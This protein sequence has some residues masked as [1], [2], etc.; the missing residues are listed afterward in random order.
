MSALTK[1]LFKNFVL[2]TFSLKMSPKHA[3]LILGPMLSK[4]LSSQQGQ[5]GRITRS[6]VK[7]KS[8]CKSLICFYILKESQRFPERKCLLN[9][10]Q[11]TKCLLNFARS[12]IC[13]WHLTLKNTVKKSWQTLT[14]QCSH[15]KGMF[16][17]VFQRFVSG[18]LI[19]K[20]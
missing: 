14:W 11:P 4:G 13:L 9:F 16:G 19:I 15:F 10:A 6:N 5:Q 20:N 8:K 3:S 2:L 12:T 7:N 1:T 18:L 17:A